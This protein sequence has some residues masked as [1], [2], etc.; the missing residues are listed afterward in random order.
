[1]LGCQ[2]CSGEP[3]AERGSRCRKSAMLVC[4]FVC[5]DLPELTNE[6]KRVDVGG[7]GKWPV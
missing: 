1:M 7:V 3:E 4:D 5:A 2:Q 6:T